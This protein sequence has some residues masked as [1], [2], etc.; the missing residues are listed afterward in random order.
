MEVNLDWMWLSLVKT[1][2]RIQPLTPTHLL[3]DWC[4]CVS[5]NRGSQKSCH[6]TPKMCSYKVLAI[7][8][9]TSAVVWSL[10][11]NSENWPYNCQGLQFQGRVHWT[12]NPSSCMAT[13]F[14]LIKVAI[15]LQTS[16]FLWPLFGLLCHWQHFGWA[17]TPHMS[18][19]MSKVI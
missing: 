19:L 17:K 1:L 18:F 5:R 13:F 3:C 12:A 2:C 15:Q 4:A 16:A 14:K 10:F 11:P 7:E 8:L 9:L 6:K